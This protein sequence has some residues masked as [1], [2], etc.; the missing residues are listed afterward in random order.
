MGYA[1]V[2]N[3][4]GFARRGVIDASLTTTDGGVLVYDNGRKLYWKVPE[5]VEM[6]TMPSE[7]ERVH[8][9]SSQWVEFVDVYRPFPDEYY[10]KF[11]I[12][13]S[14]KP[15]FFAYLPIVRNEHSISIHRRLNELPP[16]QRPA[17]V[18]EEFL[19]VLGSL[20]T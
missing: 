17:T 20:L 14:S 10:W 9:H 8:F 15:P 7:G 16:N 12:E 11:K 6:R 13:E 4:S 3:G 5:G 18:T 2:E 19:S 1:Y